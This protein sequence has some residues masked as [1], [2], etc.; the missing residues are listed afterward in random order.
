MVDIDYNGEGSG[1][2]AKDRVRNMCLVMFMVDSIMIR[3]GVCLRCEGMGEF[4]LQVNHEEWVTSQV[5][6]RGHFQGPVLGLG[7]GFL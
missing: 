5:M 6:V 2:V 4:E 1:P 3:F 7:L